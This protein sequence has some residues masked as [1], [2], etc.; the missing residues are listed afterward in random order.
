MPSKYA[1]GTSVSV[2]RSMSEIRRTLNRFGADEF[3]YAE[4]AEAIMVGFVIE[5]IQVRQTVPLPRPDD[6][7]F[8]ETPSGKW[9]RTPVQAKKAFDDEVK[10]RWRALADVIKAKLV[11]VDEDISTL[12][13]EFLS[14][15][16]LPDQ[17]TVG[18][19]VI[20]ELRRYIDTGQMPALMP[21]AKE[22]TP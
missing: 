18:E 21:G 1:E 12:E 20:P 15:M 13:Q 10:R 9:D 14:F 3:M 2:D 7:R 8:T 19:Q 17:S 4:K 6:K 5:G 22:Q 16:V 11:A